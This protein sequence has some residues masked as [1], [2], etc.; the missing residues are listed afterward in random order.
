MTIEEFRE[1]VI[2]L[3][4]ARIGWA[5]AEAY[6]NDVVGWMKRQQLVVMKKR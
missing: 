5:A 2:N 3:M 6:A 1:S 4:Q